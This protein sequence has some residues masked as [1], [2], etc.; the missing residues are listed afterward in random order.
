MNIE[1]ENFITKKMDRASTWWKRAQEAFKNGNMKA[2]ASFYYDAMRLYYECATDLIDG[3]GFKE[4][5]TK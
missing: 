4:G 3:T 2:A 1:V 5:N